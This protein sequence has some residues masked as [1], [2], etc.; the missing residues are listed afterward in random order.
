MKALYTLLMVGTLALSA[1]ADPYFYN[2]NPGEVTVKATLPSGA[3][4]SRKI[5]ASRIDFPSGYFTLHYAIEEIK[6]SIEDDAGQV[7]WSGP[8]K[9]NQIL[10]ILPPS[11][12]S[13]VV[14]AG[15]YGSNDK[16]NALVLMSMLPDNVTVDL[17][18]HNGVGAVR[19]VSVGKAFDPKNLARLSENESTWD[20]LVKQPDGSLLK[21]E[22]AVYP[23]RYIVIWKD[24][25]GKVKTASLG[26]IKP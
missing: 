17:E 18:G 21:A 1:W 10:L 7:L 8:V 12:P 15:F 20:V 6:V 4:D 3:T 22:N 11:A 2:A 24:E 16:P 13:R 14:Q 19:G 9:K 25:F 26:T 23:G 5:S